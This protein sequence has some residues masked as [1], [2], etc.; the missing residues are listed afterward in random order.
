M[1][2]AGRSGLLRPSPESLLDGLERERGERERC[3]GVRVGESESLKRRMESRRPPVSDRETLSE[4]WE[5]FQMCTGPAP[6]C[7]DVG[8]A[9]ER[10]VSPDKSARGKATEESAHTSMT[11]S[12]RPSSCRP[13]VV[14]T[15]RCRHVAHLQCRHGV[16]L[17]SR[18]SVQPKRCHVAHQS[19]CHV[20]ALSRRH[21]APQPRRHVANSRVATS[22]LWH[23]GMSLP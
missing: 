10:W 16:Q 8:E 11:A 13:S 14:S 15:R 1:P 21:V 22:H 17:N 4:V 6:P 3:T 19:C 23:V 7:G 2:A 5:K 18:H 9:L 12:C 20:V